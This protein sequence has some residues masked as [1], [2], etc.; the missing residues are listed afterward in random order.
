MNKLNNQNKPTKEGKMSQTTSTIAELIKLKRVSLG[1]TQIELAKGMFGVGTK[2]TGQM[3][4]NIENARASLPVDRINSTA[5]TLRV[6]PSEV[7][8]ALTFDYKLFL[9]K[10][11]HESK[12]K[13]DA[14]SKAKAKAKTKTTTIKTTT[15]TTK[16][17]R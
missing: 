17:K 4:S 7:I 3:V 9:A 14:R 12:K 11:S 1:V 13:I 5:S 10:K 8:D 6:H 2:A 16:G 15:T